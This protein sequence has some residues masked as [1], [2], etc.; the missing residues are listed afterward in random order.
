M[1]SSLSISLLSASLLFGACTTAPKEVP[2]TQI[3]T[4]PTSA[5]AAT[6][7]S[8][9]ASAHGGGISTAP[10]TA[11][12]MAAPQTQTPVK[13]TAPA[14]WTTGPEKPMRAATYII[15]AAAGDAEGAECAVF[16]N[17]GG[18]V[19][20][21]L[22]RWAGQFELPGGGNP[23]EKAKTSKQT[24]NGLPVTTIDL[25]GTYKGGG[26]AMG[27]ASTPKTGYR[28]LGAIVEGQSGPGSEVFFKMTG[29]VKTMAVAEKEFQTLLKSLAK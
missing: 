20:A 25:L 24:I 4:A 11:P 9:V 19:Q 27:Q 1:N 7:A 21:N 15:P 5:P 26:V 8:T 23:T 29:P 16:A 22:D 14:R 2:P 3:P 12:A 13:W 28:L 17:I 6:G 10:A 18:G